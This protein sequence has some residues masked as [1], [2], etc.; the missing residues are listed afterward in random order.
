M[1]LHKGLPH[2]M[3]DFGYKISLSNILTQAVLST[4]FVSNCPLILL[5]QPETING[6]FTLASI[7]CQDKK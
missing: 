2:K 4:F 1:T 5:A 3:P 7:V 6:E